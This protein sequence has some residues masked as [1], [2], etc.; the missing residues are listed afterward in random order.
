MAPA[1]AYERGL[2]VPRCSPPTLGRILE[3]MAQ[4]SASHHRDLMR[5]MVSELD[6]IADPAERRRFAIGAIAAII[7]LALSGYRRVAVHTLYEGPSVRYLWRGLLPGTYI[8]LV[9]GSATLIQ[10]CGLSFLLGLPWT[11]VSVVFPFGMPGSLE[12]VVFVLGIGVNAI[13]LYLIGAALDRRRLERT[14]E[15]STA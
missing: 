8:T 9:V 10:V 11:L 13:V 4:F 1:T 2:I 7:R 6:S 5:G 14:L 3:W 12:Q 15:A